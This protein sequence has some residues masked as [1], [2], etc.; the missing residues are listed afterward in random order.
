MGYTLAG[1]A[2]ATR[3]NKT[4]ILRAIKSGRISGTKNEL[5]EWHV[6]PAELHRV[7]PPIACPKADTDA[8]QRDAATLASEVHARSFLAEQRLSDLK[9]ALEEMRGQRDAWQRQAE[10]GQRLLTDSRA[11]RSWWQ[12]LA[13]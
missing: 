2:A 9:A 4:T 10:A 8:S 1:A 6:E 13:G 12:R 7:Y 5:G 3:L 11:W